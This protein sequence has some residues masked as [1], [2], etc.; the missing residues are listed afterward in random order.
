MHR[1]FFTENFCGWW[2]LQSNLQFLLL[3]DEE[4]LLQPAKVPNLH[5]FLLPAVDKMLQL[6]MLWYKLQN[7]TINHH[8]LKLC[9]VNTKSLYPSLQFCSW[10]G[11][12][13]QAEGR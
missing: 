9:D 13:A 12:C 7:K 2:Y 11:Q 6:Q 10:M 8:L 4:K 5:C 3:S 1:C